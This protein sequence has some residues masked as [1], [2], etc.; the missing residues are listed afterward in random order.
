MLSAPRQTQRLG[1]ILCQLIESD[2]LN[3][4][5]TLGRCRHIHFFSEN[6][7]FFLFLTT[8]TGSLVAFQEGEGREMGG[9]GRERGERGEGNGRERGG[10]GQ[11][12]GRDREGGLK[13]SDFQGQ[14]WGSS[15][16]YISECVLGSHQAG[17]TFFL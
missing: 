1:W 12:E 13:A 11:G 5:L 17:R 6:I 14:Q 3:D 7:H 8:P 4:F 9:R 10:R 16:Y 15:V 2:N